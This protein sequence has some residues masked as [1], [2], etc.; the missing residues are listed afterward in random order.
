MAA[1]S[2]TAG[3]ARGDRETLNRGV[4]GTVADTAEWAVASP[5]EVGA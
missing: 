5:G 4:G 3:S 2:N 1:K